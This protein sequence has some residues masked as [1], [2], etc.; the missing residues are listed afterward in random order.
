MGEEEGGRGGGEKNERWKRRKKGEGG[1]RA[2]EEGRKIS[3][4]IIVTT[5]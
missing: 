2:R 4:G 5:L 1:E 3:E